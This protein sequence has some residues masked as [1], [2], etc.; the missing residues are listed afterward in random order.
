MKPKR[1]PHPGSASRCDPPSAGCGEVF[2]SKECSSVFLPVEC[3]QH[4]VPRSEKLRL[5]LAI[6]V[7]CAAAEIGYLGGDHRAEQ[8]ASAIQLERGIR[9]IEQFRRCGTSIE[10]YLI[11]AAIQ[12]LKVSGDQAGIRKS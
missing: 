4:V 1:T 7:N 9:C 2:R 3:A 12:N 11:G 10:G 5:Q 6:V 8:V